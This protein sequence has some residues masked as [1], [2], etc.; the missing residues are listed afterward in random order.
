MGSDME[1]LALFEPA[2]QGGFVVSFPDFGGG[3]SIGAN[4]IQAIDKA[5]DL[6]RRLVQER[7]REGET[8]P[9]PGLWRGRDF[10]VVRLPDSLSSKP[11]S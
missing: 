8:L 7:I 11:Q 2:D 5:K 6:L 3:A 1:Y 4:D 10:R 9:R